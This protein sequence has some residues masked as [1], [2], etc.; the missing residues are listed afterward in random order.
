MLRKLYFVCTIIV[1]FLFGSSQVYAD[2]YKIIGDVPAVNDGTLLYLRIV[3]SPSKDIDSVLVKNGHFEFIGNAIEKPLWALIAVK[4]RFTALCDFYLE[5][6]VIEITGEKEYEAI[7]SGTKINEQYKI[8]NQITS[9]YN[10]A[11]YDINLR[12][13]MLEPQKVAEKEKLQKEFQQCEIEWEK[14]E[15]AFIKTYPDSPLSL[16]MI[17]YRARKVSSQR[18]KELISYLNEDMQQEPEMVHLKEY[19]EQLSKTEAGVEAPD[20]TLETNKGKEFTLSKERGKYLLLDF[21]ASWCAPCRASFPLIAD[22]HKQYGGTSFAVI[23]I[24]LDK[25]TQAWEKALEEEKCTW[26]QICD[27]KG[28][29]ADQ[30]AI[31]SIP[32]LLL[33]GPDGKI[34]GRY[35]KENIMEQLQQLKLK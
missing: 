29:V 33:I 9:K 35:S 5:N 12:K 23:G 2:G 34:I 14:E 6:G 18:I 3:G 27:P 15:I 4:G 20:F 30:Y 26:T 22:I 31:S 13:C 24:S 19:A 28:V 8:F 25:K 11:I 10:T 7:A 1:N 17:S 16:R 21:W 32:T